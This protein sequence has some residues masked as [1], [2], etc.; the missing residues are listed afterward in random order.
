MMAK[1]GQSLEESVSLYRWVFWGAGSNRGLITSAPLISRVLVSLSLSLCTDSVATVHSFICC[2][3]LGFLQR[4]H[5][6]EC[7]DSLFKTLCGGINRQLKQTGEKKLPEWRSSL[8]SICAQTQG[9][10][11]REEHRVGSDQQLLWIA[12]HF[13][14]QE[15]LVLKLQADR[16][17]YETMY[18][19]HVT[20]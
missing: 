3:I 1:T 11:W 9:T 14:H 7:N 16:S 17:D 20:D 2:I 12:T 18:G 10:K 4:F 8:H 15:F 19:L 6:A 13:E 5:H